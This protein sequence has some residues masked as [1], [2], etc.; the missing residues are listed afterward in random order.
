MTREEIFETIYDT[1]CTWYDMEKCGEEKTPLAATG[2]FHEST[3]SYMLIKKAQVWSADSNEYLYIYSMPVLDKDNFIR[4]VEEA[5]T[6]GEQ[7]IAPDR[8]HKCSY[9]TALFLC[10]RA[11]TEAVAA[12]KKYR[13]RKD[14]QFGL[15]GWEE[16]HTAMI[17]AEGEVVSSNRD[18]HNTEKFLN[19]I[20]H[21][22]KKSFLHK[23]KGV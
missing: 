8:Q 17:L 18:G 13:Y 15:K 4:C 7:F 3:S 12:L 11:D 9:I 20:L 23:I 5:K 14:F 1:Y 10:D 6:A 19:S 2:Q 21:P 16:V 22:K